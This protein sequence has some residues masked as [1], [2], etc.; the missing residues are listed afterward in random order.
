MQRDLNVLNHSVLLDS[1]RRIVVPG[2][3]GD[4][5]LVQRIADGSMPP[6]DEETR[7][8]RLAKEE[9]DILDRW[10]IGG[11]PPF[12]ADDPENPTP[13]VVEVSQVALEAE[14]VLQN[15]CYTCHRHD[16]AD[17]GIRI[18]HHRLLVHVRKVV[19]PGNADESE[20]FQLFASEPPHGPKSPSAEEIQKVR[21]W[22][23]DGAPPFPKTEH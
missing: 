1:D 3:P 23:D 11:A 9:L 15:R 16:Q 6:V 7:L 10:I 13:P 20:L 12:P 14:E 21:R 17:G 4:S 22:I 8:P 2:Q 19:V 5:R 18:L